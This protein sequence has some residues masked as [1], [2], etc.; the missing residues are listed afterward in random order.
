MAATREVIVDTTLPDSFTFRHM[1]GREALSEL[2][3]YRVELLSE[4]DGIVLED[5]LG[6]R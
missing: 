6:S 4:D 3:D 2:F 5:I 1:E